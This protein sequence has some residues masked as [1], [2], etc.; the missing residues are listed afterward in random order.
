MFNVLGW[1]ILWILSLLFWVG[2]IAKH[3]RLLC[4]LPCCLSLC[5][6]CGVPG[7]AKGCFCSVTLFSEFLESLCVLQHHQLNQLSFDF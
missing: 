3:L 6:G 5:R 4:G 1:I 2:E 7:G